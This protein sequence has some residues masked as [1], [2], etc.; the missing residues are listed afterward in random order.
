MF[1]PEALAQL[2]K[3]PSGSKPLAILSLGPVE[4]FY[5]APMLEIEGWRQGR[6]LHEMVFKDYWDS[7]PHSELVTKPC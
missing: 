5:P 6:P 1:D 7:R 2:L 3:M 4:N